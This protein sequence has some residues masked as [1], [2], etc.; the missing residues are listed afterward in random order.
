MPI[1]AVSIVA[2][3]HQITLRIGPFK[4]RAGNI[5]KHDVAALQMLGRQGALDG[6]LPR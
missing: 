6:L 2:K 1:L 3:E 5:I 4:I